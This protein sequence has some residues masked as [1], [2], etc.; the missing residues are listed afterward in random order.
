MQ[1]SKFIR[2]WAYKKRKKKISLFLKVA[3]CKPGRE[4]SSKPNHEVNP[5]LIPASSI[6]VRK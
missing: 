6:T 1:G 4:L 2:L 3:I 5:D